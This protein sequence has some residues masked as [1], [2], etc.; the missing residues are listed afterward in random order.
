VAGASQVAQV[1]ENPS[2]NAGDCQRLWLDPWVGK[3][4]WRREWQP[5]PVF[6]PGESH[7]WRSLAGYSPWGRKE[8][9]TTELRGTQHAQRA[10]HPSAPGPWLRIRA[11]ADVCG[12]GL[13]REPSWGSSGTSAHDGRGESRQAK[14]GRGHSD[15]QRWLK[16]CCSWVTREQV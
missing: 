5:T 10:G 14:V 3:I 8:S 15:P 1:V 9:D 7:G 16:R 13:R 11:Q 12:P 6:L 2:A 4:P